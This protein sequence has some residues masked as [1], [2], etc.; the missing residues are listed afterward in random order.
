MA[1]RLKS[2]LVW[3]F[4]VVAACC[5]LIYLSIAGEQNYMMNCHNLGLKCEEGVVHQFTR[6]AAAWLQEQGLGT[7]Y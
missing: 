3:L 1:I 2:F 5:G 7:G 4:I 6:R